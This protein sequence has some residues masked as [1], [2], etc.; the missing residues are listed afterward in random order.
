[1]AGLFVRTK[2]R[3]MTSSPD[4]QFHFWQGMDGTTPVFSTT[5]TLGR[6]SSRGRIVLSSND[7]AKYPTINPNYL[8]TDD[9][10]DILVQGIKLSREIVGQTAFNGVRGAELAPG[11]AVK[12][13]AELAAFV[14]TNSYTIYH[15]SCTCK[16]GLDHMSVVDPQLRVHGV[17][18][19]RVADASIMP[20]IINANLNATCMAIGQVAAD[21]IAAAH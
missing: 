8:S 3:P 21:L 1:M 17:E 14:R 16:M 9:D 2:H 15:V 11:P 13:D 7:P 6:P 18:G 5:P 4:L 20:S 12:T 10:V 19:L